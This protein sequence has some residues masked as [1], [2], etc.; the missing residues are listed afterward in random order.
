MSSVIDRR[1]FL[2]NA[3]VASIGAYCSGKAGF[4]ATV[5]PEGMILGIGNYGMKSLTVEESIRQIHSTGFGGIE[6]TMMPEWDSAPSQLSPDRRTSIRQQLK[7]RGLILCSLMEDLPIP[8]EKAAQQKVLERFKL[9]AQLG[10]DLAPDNPPLIQTI[11]GGGKWDDRKELYRDVLGDWLQFAKANTTVIA[12]KPHRSG[13]MSTPARAAWLLQQLGNPAEI[14]MVYDY[15]HYA[16]RDLS[17]P[18]TVADAYSGTVQIAVKDIVARGSQWEFALPGSSGTIDYA[19]ILRDFYQRGYR[20]SVICEVSSQVFRQANYDAA[21]A[22]Q[23]CFQSMKRIFEQCQ[24]P[25]RSAAPAA[26]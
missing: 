4:A 14:G 13:A 10:Q 21:A 25:L 15:S 6:L 18:T 22:T 7:D 9:A 2:K 12:I 16:L 20:Q 8:V 26:L 5:L 17:I 11:L 19:E 23:A 3:A 24:L 1:Q